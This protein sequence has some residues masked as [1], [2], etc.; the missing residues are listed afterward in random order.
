MFYAFTIYYVF[1][2]TTNS[3]NILAKCI[4]FTMVLNTNHSSCSILS[5]FVSILILLWDICCF[6]L[7]VHKFHILDLLLLVTQYVP[8]I[9]REHTQETLI[10]KIKLFSLLHRRRATTECETKNVIKTLKSF[11]HKEHGLN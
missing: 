3:S 5:Y 9:F 8:L 2:A 1:K 6:T 4:L 11:L 10:A 7:Y